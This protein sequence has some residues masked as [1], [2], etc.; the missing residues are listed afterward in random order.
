MM[1]DYYVLQKTDDVWVICVYRDDMYYT[2][3]DIMMIDI[4]EER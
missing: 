1:C 3:G 2:K 4:F